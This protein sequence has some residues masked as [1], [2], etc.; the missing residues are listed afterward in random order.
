MHVAVL[1]VEL[2][3]PESRS[4]KAKRSLLKPI[5]EGVRRR[6]PVAVAEVAYQDKWQRSGLGVAVVAG[7]PHH[8]TRVLDAVERYVWSS[9][10]VE[11]VS[12]RRAWMDTEES[13]P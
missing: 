9:A 8:A 11:V 2:R 6:F 13:S 12:M 3:F 4:I 10:E 5:V 1:D 7:D